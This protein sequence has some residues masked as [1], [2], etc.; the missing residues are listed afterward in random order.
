MTIQAELWQL[1]LA[2]LIPTIAV[3]F[4]SGVQAQKID[5]LEQKVKK[6]EAMSA[7]LAEIKND[8]KWVK[9]A[10]AYA[11]RDKFSDR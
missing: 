1:I 9:E 11:T 7:T 5:E 8:M 3:V 2:S 10:L 4:R 6:V